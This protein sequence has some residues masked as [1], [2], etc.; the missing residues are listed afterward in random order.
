MHLEFSITAPNTS[1]TMSCWSVSQALSTKSRI[2]GH[3]LGRK[4]LYPPSS[5]K[6][7]WNLLRPLSWVEWSLNFKQFNRIIKFC[8]LQSKRTVASATFLHLTSSW[9]SSITKDGPKLRSNVPAAQMMS[10]DAPIWSVAC[11][12]WNA[13]ITC[14]S[15]KVASLLTDFWIG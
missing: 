10:S 13:G 12:Q 5:R 7:M 11:N 14:Y 6:H 3:I 9:C 8:A 15:I 1:I 4:R 2:P